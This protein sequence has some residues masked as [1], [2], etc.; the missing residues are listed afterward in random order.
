MGKM[1]QHLGP[2]SD[3]VLRPK[4]EGHRIPS[5]RLEKKRRKKSAKVWVGTI[6]LPHLAPA[7][8]L[9]QY[10]QDDNLFTPE[11]M[12]EAHDRLTTHYANTG[13]P[14][15]ISVSFSQDLTN[16]IW[17]CSPLHLIG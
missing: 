10:D 2:Y 13:V 9:V 8:L 7:P 11:G 5:P 15:V 3:I 12:Q 17:K 4:G 6:C 14:E 16:L 1:F